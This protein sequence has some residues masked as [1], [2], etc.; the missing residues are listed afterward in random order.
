MFTTFRPQ[1]R[2]VKSLPATGVAIAEPLPA[3][4]PDRRPIWLK[5]LPLAMVVLMVGTLAMFV[6]MGQRAIGS[7][8]FTLP[9]M[10]FMM[11]TYFQTMR[12]GGNSGEELDQQIEDYDLA[13]R[14]TR[15]QIYDQGRAMHDL[16]TTCFPHP[17]DLLSLVGTDEMWQADRSPDLGIVVTAEA[18][19]ED[20]DVKNL[21]ANPWLRARIGIGVAPLYPKLRVPDELPVPEMLEPA[22][23]VRYQR[24]MNT[25]S[26]VANIPI[27]VNLGEFPAYALRGNEAA[28]LDLARAMV[29]SLAFNHRP[30]DLAIGVVT[31]DPASWEWVKWLPHLEDLSRVEKGFGARLLTWRSLDEFAAHHAGAIER[32]RVAG[33]DD[34]PAHLLLIVD[35]PDQVVS[36]PPNMAGGVNGMTWLV[37]RYG[38]DLVSVEESRILI[39]DDRVSTIRD[40]DAATRDIISPVAAEAFARAM[41][42][43]R[44]R[45]Y[46][47]S[48][49]VADDRPDHIPDFFEALR[50]GDI[51]TYDLIKVWRDNAYTNEIRVPF[52]YYRNG[53]EILPELAHLNFYDMNRDGDGPHGGVQ[54]VTGSGKSYFLR[55]V[56]LSMVARYGPEKVALI[57]A[58]FK[59]G[60][61]FIGMDALPH[62][63]ANISNLENA[64]EL[65]E[66]LGAVLQGEVDRRM[67][68]I[69]GDKNL[70][71]IFSYRAEQQRRAGDPEWPPLPD[72]IVIIDEFGE[73]LKKNP[74]YMALLVS[75]GRIGRTLGI[76]LMMCSQFLD[77]TILGDLL[78]QTTYRFSLAVQSESQSRNFIGSD[79]AGRITAVKGGLKGKILQK[80]PSDSAPVEVVAFH[81]EAP[82]VRRSITER[83]RSGGG[84]ATESVADAVVPFTLFTSRG[85]TPPV[86]EGEVVE[87]E[88]GEA[89]SDTDTMAEVLLEK[90]E[91]FTDMRV[92]DLWKPSLR[93]PVSLSTA[94][95]GLSRETRGLRIR[96]G[97]LDAPQQHA[98]L[99][100]FIDLGG[101]VPHQVIAGGGRSGRTTTLQT[102][103]ISGCLQHRPNRLAFMLADYGA[104]KLGEV[105]TSPNVAAYARPGDEDTVYR[106]LGEASRLIDVR[107]AAMVDREVSSMDAYL[108]SKEAEPVPGDPYG[109]MIV[110]IDGIGG[111]LGEDSDQRRERS[112]LL[113]PILDRGAASGVH[114]IYTGDGMGSGSS[115]NY[116]HY[117][118]E[119]NGGVQLAST[120][121]TGVK[122][123]NEVR[124]SLPNL[125]PPDQPGRSYDAAT[126]LQ[127]RVMVPINREV[128][129]DRMDKGLPVFEV[130]DH[131]Q[132][133]RELCAQ[134]PDALGGV[135]VTPVLPAAPDI[136]FEVVWS[137]FSPLV[138]MNRNPAR[139]II[140]LGVRMDT[141][142][143]APIPNY[144]ANLL[145]Y[146]EKQSGRTN[147]LRVAME[148]V[149]RQFTPEQA[150]IIVIDPL[151]NLLVDRDAL[152]ARGFMQAPRF[153]DPDE[154]GERRRL[155]PPG[156]V[157]SD[158]DLRET[159]KMLSALMLKRRPT[160]DATAEQ[161][162]E[163][164]YFTGKE[165]YVFIDG[166]FRLTEG[167]MGRSVFDDDQASAG[168]SVTR[169]LA[170]GDDLGVHFIVADDTGFADRVKSAPFLVALRDKQMAPILQLAAQPSS[171]APVGQAFHLKPQRWRTGQGRLIVDAEDYTLVQ[172]AHLRSGD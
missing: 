94:A 153:S 101:A 111:F 20:P 114:L 52:G 65:V 135:A 38:S 172:V 42:R 129:P 51:E 10:G 27:D 162:R 137:Q 50:I 57:L 48:G 60:A 26:V 1:E 116:S 115:G 3:P 15:N 98:R 63:V 107:R 120:D 104:G 56:V 122:M 145:V 132:E 35:T 133:I 118:F 165:I 97:D 85:F 23:M 47:M 88:N 71:D 92:L 150:A 126:S 61:T 171:G 91:R 169:L 146:G 9:M 128:E 40:Y 152:Y 142:E 8:L 134:L 168:E 67:Q 161:L 41:Y 62:T 86:I 164:T 108:A 158:G 73:F 140:P 163:R 29:M 121:Y 31:E 148:S 21:T 44:P 13:L 34:R 64:T 59:G 75:I 14:E 144:S 82:Y 6:S 2:L 119:L 170:S 102:L 156:Y 167:M 154:S 22:T 138:D 25:L 109:Y 159:V 80:L 139:T 69:T 39:E 4:P 77:K 30:G 74:Q 131:G 17:A 105:R 151:R 99:P 81:H 33:D 53:D 28:R 16:R 84:D 125:I 87:V 11:V 54:G 76:H 166:F 136:D 70:P 32:M 19:A 7:M 113:R 147:A 36:W 93:E 112:R 117:S 55:A 78:D 100:W 24:A 68:F 5:V 149:M 79:A 155:S 124:M 160:D 43:Y 90:I 143:L 49:V 46:G 66:R 96:I 123:P 157:T 110:A 45:G 141:L 37:V 72:L 12:S 95:G 130:T 103:V 127:A 89:D 58:D 18:M 106:I 83:S